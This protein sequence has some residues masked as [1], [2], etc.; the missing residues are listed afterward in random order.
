MRCVQGERRRPNAELMDVEPL[1]GHMDGMSGRI[2]RWSS[3]RATSS[4]SVSRVPCV[5]SRKRCGVG[6]IFSPNTGLAV[7]W[8]IFSQRPR[9]A[10]GTGVVFVDGAGQAAGS[11]ARGV[12]DATLSRQLA[13]SNRR[14]FG[15]ESCCSG[16]FAQTRT[17]A[18]AKST[19]RRKVEYVHQSERLFCARTA[20]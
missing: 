12:G 5:T 13:G 6:T 10:A 16:R 17:A 15:A 8:P 9:A 2:P 3:R 20:S 18:A 4:E 7:R 14:A 19:R 11:T 1:T